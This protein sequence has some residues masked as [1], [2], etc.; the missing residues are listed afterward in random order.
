MF[1]NIG[2]KIKGLAALVCWLGIISSALTAVGLWAADQAVFAIVVLI[3][4]FFISWVGSFQTYA[5]GEIADNTA[6]QAEMLAKLYEEQ[7][8]L[9]EKLVQMAN[10]GNE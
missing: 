5:L 4:G 8:M 6:K 1:K 2:R 9:N 3:V 10:A 7:K